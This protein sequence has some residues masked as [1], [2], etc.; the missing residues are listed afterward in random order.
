MTA[1]RAFLY[2]VAAWLFA[3]FAVTALVASLEP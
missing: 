3:A 2:F 1:A